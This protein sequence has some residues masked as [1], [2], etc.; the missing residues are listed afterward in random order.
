MKKRLT[1]MCA[2]LFLCVGIGYAQI[3]VT[4]TVVSKEDGEAIIGATVTVVGTKTATVTDLNGNFKITVPNGSAKLQISYVGYESAIVTAKPKMNVVLTTS[5]QAL[6]A[7][8]VT[9]YGSAKKLGTIAGSVETVTS[10]KFENRPIANIGDAL[11]GEVAG[12]QVFTSSGEPSASVSMRIRGVTSINASTSPLYILDGSEIT[13]DAFNALNPNDIA[14]MT[15]LKD[16]S[17]TA[18]YGSRAANGVLILTSK[19]GKAGQ[20]PTITIGAQYGVSKMTGD[21]VTMMNANQWLDFQELADPGKKND[22]DFQAMKAYYNK[23]GIST[24]WSDVF[25]G[26]S[27]PTSQVDAS[28]VGGSDMFTY[29]LSYGHYTMDGI[30]DDSNLRRETLRANIEANINSWLKVGT[31]TGLSYKKYGTSAFGTTSNSVYNKVFA[32]RT[33]IPVQTYNE[34]L[35]LKYRED[36]SVDYANSTFEGFGN[37]YDYFSM[38][39]YY[40]PYYLSEIQPSTRDNTRITE[41]AFI[42]INP[43][44]GLNWRTNVGLEWFDYRSTAKV[45]PVGPFEGAGNAYEVFER[46]YNWTVSN[47]LEYKFDIAKR[48]YFTALLGHEYMYNKDRAFSLETEGQTDPRLMLPSAGAKAT[49]PSSDSLSEEKRLSWFGMLN[50]DLDDKYFVDLSI[51]RDGSSLFDRDHYWA[52]FG[53][54]AA[55]WNISRENFMAPTNSWLNDLAVKVSYGTTGNSGIA[56]YNALGL[57]G[58]GPIYDGKGGTALANPSNP[59]LTWE[60]VKTFNLALTGR[61]F[62]FLSFDLEYY[63]KITSDMIMSIP[64]SVTTGFSSGV[65][66]V[67]EMRNRGFDFTLNFDLIKTK[68]WMWTLN[69]NGN[70]NSNKITKL[71][72]GL[73]EYVLNNTGLKMQ[74]DHPYGEYYYVRWSHVDPR[75][76]QNVWLDKNG[77]ETKIFSEDNA[78]MTGKQRYAP[79]SGG[80]MTTVAWKGLQLDLQFTG[81]FDRY[82][83]NNER[84]FTENGT[85]ASS[86]NQ[87]TTM[88]DMWTTPGQV[89]DIP[90]VDADVEF[91]THLLEEASFVRLKMLQL[92]YTFPTSLMQKTGFIKGAKVYFIGRNLLTFTGYKGYDPEVDSNITLG[93]Y[94]NTR[95]YSIGAQL[96]F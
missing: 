52:T 17:A 78:V 55:M 71:F 79:W 64:Y 62:D 87:S 18:I 48:H 24:D 15:V 14:S 8:V 93:N 11:Q 95:Q 19:R 4:G 70:Y 65:G 40:N 56:P 66:N 39:D 60:T 69:I 25:F 72:Q 36:G 9:G 51:R 50:Y 90:A 42:N 86:H 12:L 6:D 96:T 59:D 89:T 88:L 94:P 20:T 1:M 31:N 80:A 26:G 34:I 13:S 57:V 3:Q 53:A 67:A 23:Y 10:D 81:M 44:K 16:A 84:Y 75:D 35:G 54:A 32:S 29:L 85:F 2:L 49:L 7:L 76:G 61:V 58:T 73:D 91:D 22:A 43:L 21:K 46:Y 74:V 33:Y 5:A 30:M 41:N 45:L 38:M 37:R 47:T 27:A 77:N 82:M 92:S 83:I 28:I 68:D 63:N